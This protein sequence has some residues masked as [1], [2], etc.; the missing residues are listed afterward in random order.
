MLNIKSL[1]HV[2]SLVSLQNTGKTVNN[3]NVETL[4]EHSLS[5]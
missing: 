5:T 3:D 2:L 1:F 4:R